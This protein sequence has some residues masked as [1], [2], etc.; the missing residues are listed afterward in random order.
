MYEELRMLCIDDEPS[1]LKAVIPL[2][3]YNCKQGIFKWSDVAK[4]F[5]V[6]KRSGKQCKERWMN[7]LDPNLKKHPWTHDE[8]LQLMEAQRRLGNSWT[9]IALEIDGRG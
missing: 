2:Y 5:T 6:A 3:I 1:N 9:K 8:D 4:Q 7:H